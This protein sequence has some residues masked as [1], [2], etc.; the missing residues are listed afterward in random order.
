MPPFPTVPHPPHTFRSMMPGIQDM[1]ADVCKGK[2]IDYDEWIKGLKSKGQVR[3]CAHD[4]ELLLVAAALL[5]PGGQASPPA[6][7][8]PSDLPP[9][10]AP[11]HPRAP[12]PPPPPAP[13]RSHPPPGTPALPP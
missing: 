13:P 3:A 5:L 7:P 8:P 1:L 6:R 10:P 12:T 11:P 4:P 2:S 9:P